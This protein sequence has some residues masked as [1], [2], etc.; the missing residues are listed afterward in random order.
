MGGLNPFDL[1][2]LNYDMAEMGME[3]GAIV[4]MRTLGMMGLWGVKKT[5]VYDMIAEKPAAF[6]E[7]WS[8]GLAAAMKGAGPDR[9]IAA[10]LVPIGKKTR[11]NHRRLSRLGLRPY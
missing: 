4:T 7:A 3:A 9:V 2:R 8:L 10:S 11:S 1:W 6:A 5:E